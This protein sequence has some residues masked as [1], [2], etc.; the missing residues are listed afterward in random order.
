MKLGAIRR[1]RNADELMR[2]EIKRRAFREFR[3][4]C[5]PNRF[6]IRFVSDA[7]LT[8]PFNNNLA[9]QQFHRRPLSTRAETRQQRI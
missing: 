9:Q 5:D 6:L 1:A 3:I 8:R 4:L 7:K 2:E